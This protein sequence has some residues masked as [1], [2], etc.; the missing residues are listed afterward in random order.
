MKAHRLLLFSITAAVIVA[1]A[2]WALSIPLVEVGPAAMAVL[3]AAP[4]AL[5]IE[6]ELRRATASPSPRSDLADARFP[7]PLTGQPQATAFG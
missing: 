5:A 3:I 1:A 6:H 4:L 2:S 7:A